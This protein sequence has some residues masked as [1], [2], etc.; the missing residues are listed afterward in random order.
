M[1]ITYNRKET[2]NLGNFEHLSIEIGVTDEVRFENESIDECFQRL[3]KFVHAGLE[4]QL[5][6][7][8]KIKK[9]PDKPVPAITINPSAKAE[10]I[11]IGASDLQHF[12]N[13]ETTRNYLKEISRLKDGNK[14]KINTIFSKYGAGNIENLTPE[15]LRGFID[16]VNEKVAK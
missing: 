4:S 9:Q 7:S 1:L 14:D 15:Q 13:V 5:K 2:R 12:V 6:K 3:Q 11:E 8:P 10:T 16:E